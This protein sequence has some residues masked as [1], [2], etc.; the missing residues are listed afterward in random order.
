MRLYL[1]S[2]RLGDAARLL[3][4]LMRGTRACVVANALDFI[5]DEAR[6]R[7]AERV[8][9]PIEEFG[10]QGIHAEYLDLRAHFDSRKT[11]RSALARYDLVWVLG[12]NAFLLRRAMALSGFDRTIRTMLAE[13]AIAYGGFSAGAVVAAPTLRGIHLMDSPTQ[14]AE[15]YPQAPMWQ[16]L[17]LIDFSL[18]PHFRSNHPEAPAAEAAAKYFEGMQL[19]FKTLRDGDVWIR[20]GSVE[21]L[22][23][24]S[25]AT[26]AREPDA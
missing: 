15:G 9:D 25:S 14:V 21:A 2:Y 19:P 20:D 4:P 24:R 1:S 12:G 8:Y 6:V 22:W 17:A 18:V 7:H 10:G 11:M 23:P 13:D 26:H 3:P 16:G 5:P